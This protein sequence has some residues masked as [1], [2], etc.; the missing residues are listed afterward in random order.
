[1]K[2]ERLDKIIEDHARYRAG[3]EGGKKANLANESLKGLTI[4]TANLNEAIF[5]NC[6]ID[7]CTL[8]NSKMNNTCFMNTHILNSRIVNVELGKADFM[9]SKIQF[10]YIR[11]NSLWRAKFNHATI[12]YTDFSANICKEADFTKANLTR[13]NF[14]GCDLTSADLNGI[15]IIGTIGNGEEIKTIQTEELGIITYTEEVMSVNIHQNSLKWWWESTDKELLEDLFDKY[16]PHYKKWK[17]ILKAIGVFDSITNLDTYT[18]VIENIIKKKDRK[19][20]VADHIG[21]MNN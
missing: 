12:E 8:Y 16:I 10:S 9:Y 3:M 7:G 17:P 5:V 21:C 4:H 18:E 2:Q 6:I 11:S 13:S 15:N 19:I 14:T 20:I 1:M